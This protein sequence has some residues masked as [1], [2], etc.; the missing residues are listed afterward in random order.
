MSSALAELERDSKCK[1]IHA[2]EVRR[3]EKEALETTERQL[4]RF[5]R[6][7]LGNGTDFTEQSESRQQ[8][9][10]WLEQCRALADVLMEQRQSEHPA[11]TSSSTTTTALNSTM[12]CASAAA[13]LGGIAQ[14]FAQACEDGNRTAAE[15]IKDLHARLNPDAKN[16]S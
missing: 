8:A 7:P 5:V 2:A 11:S 16:E 13:V 9:N 3:A 14:S 1:A 12:L 10:L 15:M 6:E 4:R